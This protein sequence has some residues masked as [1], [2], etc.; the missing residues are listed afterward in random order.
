[1]KSRIALH[2]IKFPL[3]LI[4]LLQCLFQGGAAEFTVESPTDGRKFT[5]SD[6]RGKYVALHF[7]LKTECPVCLKNTREHA[8]AAATQTDVVH[9]FL[10]PDSPE[11]IRRWSRGINPGSSTNRV[12]IYRDPNATLA[13]RFQIPGGYHFH[14]ETMHFPALV[15]L[16]ESGTEVFRHV[17][18]DNTDR[19]SVAQ[20]Q[21]KLDALKKTRPSPSPAPDGAKP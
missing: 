7:L 14:G 20:L 15:L 10:K 2:P 16:D 17:G 3:L 6:A 4:A 18:K 1:M 12:T 5:L 8:K 9:V 11:E 19:F 13:K 21:S